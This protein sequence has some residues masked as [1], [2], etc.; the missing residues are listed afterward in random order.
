ML[1]QTLDQSAPNE[2][3]CARHEDQIIFADDKTAVFAFTHIA[4][5]SSNVLLLNRPYPQERKKFS[6]VI[7]H[8]D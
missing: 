5:L 4:F 2:A 7:K 8:F 3:S 6:Q 1:P